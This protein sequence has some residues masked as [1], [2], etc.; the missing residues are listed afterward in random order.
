MHPDW[1]PMSMHYVSRLQPHLQAS[2]LF[3]PLL[4]KTL[5]R[6]L[7]ER[8]DKRE[9]A[10]IA[11][12]E[13][14]KDTRRFV[15]KGSE[16]TPLAKP[17]EG[18]PA[19]PLV[20]ML[21]ASKNPA[22]MFP[23]IESALSEHAQRYEVARHIVRRTYSAYERLPLGVTVNH[24]ERGRGIIVEVMPDMRRV[25]RFDK[26][27]ETHRYSPHSLYKLMED[28]RK[29]GGPACSGN[30]DRAVASKTVVPELHH[31]LQIIRAGEAAALAVL[32]RDEALKVEELNQ[33]RALASHALRQRAIER[34]MARQRKKRD[35]E[36][37]K[38]ERLAALEKQLPATEHGKASFVDMVARAVVD[39]Q[40]FAHL[41]VI[42]S[43]FKDE[44]WLCDVEEEAQKRS[45]EQLRL[46]LKTLREG[47]AP[48]ADAPGAP[49]E[50]AKRALVLAQLSARGV[51]L[52]SV[53]DEA[54]TAELK[55]QDGH[56]GRTVNR[57]LNRQRAGAIVVTAHAGGAAGS[58]AANPDEAA[59]LEKEHEDLVWQL[60]DARQQKKRD[61]KDKAA[62]VLAQRGVKEVE[63]PKEGHPLAPG[64]G[65]GKDPYAAGKMA[66]QLAET[67]HL[68]VKHDDELN[69]VE[70]L[71]KKLDKNRSSSLVAGLT[72]RRLALQEE[73]EQ[74]EVA[75]QASQSSQTPAQAASQA[76]QAAEA[77]QAMQASQASRA[78][79][80][81]Q[82][83]EAVAAAAEDA[84][85]QAARATRA[86]HLQA[87][88]AACA[89][90]S[91]RPSRP[92]STRPSGRASPAPS[93]GSMGSVDSSPSLAGGGNHSKRFRGPLPDHMPPE[94][95][96]QMLRSSS[97]QALLRARKSNS[98]LA[99]PTR[100]ALEQLELRR[101]VLGE[102]SADGA[103][104]IEAASRTSSFASRT[105]SANTPRLALRKP[106]VNTGVATPLQKPA[107]HKSCSPRSSCEAGSDGGSDVYRSGGSAVSSAR[108]RSSLRPI[109]ALDI[110]LPHW[111]SEPL[112][113]L[114]AQ[115]RLAAAQRPS[116]RNT[117]E[118]FVSVGGQQELVSRPIP[119]PPPRTMRLVMG[120]KRTS[121]LRPARAK[122]RPDSGFKP[123]AGWD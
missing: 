120:T 41:A 9:K 30:Y 106:S 92:S 1:H 60:V 54:I 68:R 104:Q 89:E 86:S 39:G 7:Y 94:P 34:I 108:S 43:T 29:T 93:V 26:G 23:F 123:S 110:D 22:S 71:L 78:L 25:V 72:A 97:S 121:K 42:A 87:C 14:K 3:I 69:K 111:A 76:L 83:A 107:R 18:K 70:G 90:G 62:H 91:H 119:A 6:V 16:P 80:A 38:S 15:V 88:A 96:P 45:T 58:G 17:P 102:S 10:K 118:V 114:A 48:G 81:A 21:A 44:R 61:D 66:A 63:K 52:G 49:P 33:L 57:L 35:V 105:V 36:R 117:E 73:E 12:A 31:T 74:W 53:D 85:L 79:T 13:R 19:Q 65:A 5:L 20:G 115:Q 56:V 37:E 46:E 55:A 40:A 27:G 101:R 2:A 32:A 112:D 50:D 100:A 116:S 64:S 103:K 99:T 67:E 95:T 122:T 11:E 82:T 98:G 51:A 77:M 75:S 4:A 109:S 28:T 84:R 47:A 113:T 24:P 59:A 8:S